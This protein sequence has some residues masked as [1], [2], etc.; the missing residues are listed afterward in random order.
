[1]LI[2]ERAVGDVTELRRRAGGERR[3]EQKDALMAMALAVEGMQTAELQRALGRSRGLVQ[4]WAYACRDGEVDAV[5]DKPRGGKLAKLRG[6]NLVRLKAR[7]DAGPTARDKVCTLR[8]KDI[9]R[10]ARDELNTGVSLSSVYR[11]LEQRGTPRWRRAHATRSRTPRLRRSSNV[12]APPFCEDRGRVVVPARGDG[13]GL[14]HGRP[15]T[16]TLRSTRDAG[17]R[18]GAAWVATDGREADTLRVGLSLRGR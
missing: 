3:S 10:I 11:T 6:E 7:I 5:I 14:L 1:M 12:R 17:A 18:V 2:R 13:A 4:R 15:P 16:S 9:Q 8:G